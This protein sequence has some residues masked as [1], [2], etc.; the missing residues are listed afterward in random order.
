VT[1]LAWAIMFALAVALILALGVGAPWQVLALFGLLVIA[2]LGVGFLV[3]RDARHRG[4][5]DAER[6]A[7][8]VVVWGFLGVLVYG[9]HRRQLRR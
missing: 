2:W 8:Q 1:P 7:A 3:Y 6:S 9:E 5:P 4:D